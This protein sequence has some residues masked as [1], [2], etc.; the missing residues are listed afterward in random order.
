M[1]KNPSLSGS[2]SN[3]DNIHPFNFIFKN[4]W[5][6]SRKNNFFHFIFFFSPTIYEALRH[7][8]WILW[9]T[10]RAEQMEQADKKQSDHKTTQKLKK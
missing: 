3:R 9:L 1:C 6:S 5:N 7:F 10:D 8:T 2:N 4:G